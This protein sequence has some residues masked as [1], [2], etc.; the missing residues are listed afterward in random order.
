MFCLLAPHT[1]CV[2]D[3]SVGRATMKT[4][5]SA[6]VSGV[7]VRMKSST[8]S[9]F[10]IRRPFWMLSVITGRRLSVACVSVLPPATLLAQDEILPP[11]TVVTVPVVSV[12]SNHSVSPA[13][14]V[15]LATA[16][17]S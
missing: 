7:A 12:A 2:A 6:K 11:A 16:A 1:A 8:P 4:V 5:L 15:G 10:A 9:N 17:I 14:S 13:I 3:T